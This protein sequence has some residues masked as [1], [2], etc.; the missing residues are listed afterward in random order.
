MKAL[1]GS[2]T[3]EISLVRGLLELS[4]GVVDHQ[5]HAFD[6]EYTVGDNFDLCKALVGVTDTNPFGDFDPTE[7]YNTLLKSK[8][9]LND[10]DISPF[11]M[12]VWSMEMME[13]YPSASRTD[14]WYAVVSN[15]PD[16]C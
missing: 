2:E 9:F 15:E 11:V 4:G 12:A 14:I 6:Q 13:S 10:T 7:M 5:Q 3:Q 8:G 16:D 1:Q